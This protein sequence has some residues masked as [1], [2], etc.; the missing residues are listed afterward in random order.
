[1][2][3]PSPAAQL[4]GLLARFSP[5]VRAVARG[6]LARMR[7][8]VPGAVEL[9]YDNYNGLVIGFSSTERA[10]D[11]VFS[12]VLYPRW[13]NLFFLHGATLTDPKKLLKG[14]GVRVR[15]IALESATQLDTPAVRALIRQALAQRPLV[16]RGRRL[17][18][19]AIQPKQRPRRR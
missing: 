16:G 3:A 8:H 4:Q 14:N 18:I 6:T 15:H 10:G 7:K 1:M 11:A 12:I 9:V 17:V 19:R 13:V 5:E 2:K